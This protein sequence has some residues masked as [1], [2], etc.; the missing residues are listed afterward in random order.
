MQALFCWYTY[1]TNKG[2]LM[3]KVLLLLIVLT[4]IFPA[5][6]LAGVLSV[7][8]APSRSKAPFV[9]A[10]KLEQFPFAEDAELL[11]VD[12]INIKIGDAILLRCGGESMLVD[13]GTSDKLSWLEFFF[14]SQGITGFTYYMN[15]HSHDDHLN[16][17]IRLVQ[18]GYPAAAFLSKYSR[19]TR[20]P[21]IVK[22][23]SALDKRGIPHHQLLPGDRMT[24]GGAEITFI[25]NTRQD[26]N[27]SGVNDRS[28]MLHIRYKNRTML[29]PADVTGISL[30]QVME[31]YPQYMNVDIMK[32][33]H[34]GINRLR[35][36]FFEASD[37]ELI[38]ITSNMRNG[39]TLAKQLRSYKIPHYYI[40][41]G[42]VSAQTDGEIWYVEQLPLPGK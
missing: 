3:K 42:T 12:F 24:L 30:G 13:G 16:A 20:L 5:A 40:S 34:H 29:L 8:H 23:M 10:P 21:E 33:P 27:S 39:E 26:E 25:Q 28:M 4:L 41:M 19:E 36:E 15:T 17:A 18:K 31:D 14:E 38:V 32:S 9:E 6:A 11:R 35:S 22:L 1:L 7:Y 2:K 37:P